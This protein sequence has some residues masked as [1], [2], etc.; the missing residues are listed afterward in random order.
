MPAGV[1]RDEAVDG[2]Q[3]A[4]L[5]EQVGRGHCGNPTKQSNMTQHSHDVCVKIKRRKHIRVR[6]QSPTCIF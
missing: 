4:V 5:P 6:F 1:W 2:V 3:P